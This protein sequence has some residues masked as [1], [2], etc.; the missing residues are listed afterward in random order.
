VKAFDPIDDWFEKGFRVR[1]TKSAKGVARSA[2]RD[3]VRSRSGSP[4]KPGSVKFSPDAKAKNATSVIRKAPEVMVKITGSSSGLA[5]V[6][7]HLDYISRNGNV[8]LEDESGT[9]Y[10]GRDDV[11]N[12][13]EGLKACNIPEESKKREF[14]HVIFSMPPG[15]P[16]DKTK[17]AVLK[18]CREEFSNRQWVAAMHN[19]TDHTHVHVCVGT[20]DI[21]RADEPRLS[22]RKA[23]LARW[24]QGF[25]EKLRENGIEAAASE[26]RNRFQYRRGES[27]AVRQIR[28]DNPRSA[29]FNARR[30]TQR[31]QAKRENATKRP[32]K[33]FIGPPRPARVPRVTEALGKEMKAA[34]ASKT[35][36]TNPAAQAMESSR[37]KTLAGWQAVHERL[38]AS[39]EK[40]LAAELEKLLAEGQKPV[41]SRNQDLFDQAEAA[42]GNTKG[43]DKGTDQEPSL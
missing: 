18:F 3:G 32:N 14:L 35:R 34:I 24:R 12:L 6:K 11:K 16:A 43:Q 22:P 28:A 41:T 19:D 42:Q 29:V 40:D 36:P 10:R 27:A 13:R 23:D 5:T 31:A 8:E 21:D 33:A 7:H 39:G 15:T 9:L 26:R 37:Q 17:D 38:Q 20:R 1:R 30:A 2:R 25:A 4:A